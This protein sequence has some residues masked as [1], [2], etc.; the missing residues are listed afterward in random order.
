MK[1]LLKT[2][3]IIIGLIVALFV[4]DKLA[5][6]CHIEGVCRPELFEFLK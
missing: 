1:K 2:I 4:F 3:G 5:P 6:R